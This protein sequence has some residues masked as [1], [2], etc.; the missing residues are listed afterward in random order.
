MSTP[1]T[2]S[3]PVPYVGAVVLGHARL[4]ARLAESGPMYLANLRRLVGPAMDGTVL[5]PPTQAVD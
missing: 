1:I 3:A 4:A 5:I 2:C